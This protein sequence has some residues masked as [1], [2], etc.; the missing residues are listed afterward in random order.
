MAVAVLIIFGTP[1]STWLEQERSAA[2]TA[3]IGWAAL[4]EEVIGWVSRAWM[5]FYI[6][7]R[8]SAGLESKYILSGPQQNTSETLYFPS[9]IYGYTKQ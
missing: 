3:E 7:M 2:I 1:S 8:K 4:T 9:F 6:R 5:G